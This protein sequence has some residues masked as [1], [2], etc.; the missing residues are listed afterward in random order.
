MSDDKRDVREH[1]AEQSEST[2]HLPSSTPQGAKVDIPCSVVE[3]KGRHIQLRSKQLIP[4]SMP[5]SVE[6]EDALY[7]GEVVHCI[8]EGSEY[9]V[10]I[11]V[12]QVLTGLQSLVSL[13]A[14][15]LDEQA[16]SE[17]SQ[18]QKL[19]ADETKVMVRRREDSREGHRE[20]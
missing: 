1:Y 2:I 12:E 20:K 19:E 15:L 7:L 10:N 18:D 9:T 6:H 5:L 16:A 13:R 17:R 8:M 11:E 3:I 14:R 4:A